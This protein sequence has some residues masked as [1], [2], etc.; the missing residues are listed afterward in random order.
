MDTNNI[1]DLEELAK[2]LPKG[3]EKD[4][5]SKVLAEAKRF[6]VMPDEAVKA[7]LK[8]AE[9]EAAD[10]EDQLK[11]LKMGE[12]ERRKELEGRR[13]KAWLTK[14]AAEKEWEE[15]MAAVAP[16]LIE[17][18]IVRRKGEAEAEKTI[19]SEKIGDLLENLKS[20]LAKNDLS[21]CGAVLKKLAVS[22]RTGEVL[23]YYGYPSNL[24]GLHK[25]FNEAIISGRQVQGEK[26]YDNLLF[27]QK[28]YAIE[29]EISCLAAGQNQWSLAFSVGR[30]GRVGQE[31][32]EQD[33]LTAVLW[34]V[35]KIKPETA[36]RHFGPAAYGY[37]V[38]REKGKVGAGSDFI[39]G[40]EGKLTLMLYWKI[41][42]KQL[43]K[44]VFNTE[45]AEAI[46]ST[47]EEFA[48]LGLP[49]SFGEALKKY[50]EETKNR[51]EAAEEVWK[52]IKNI[53]A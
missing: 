8:M 37:F 16:V 5:W 42:E 31:L 51:P 24:S 34:A 47:E 23:N 44:K 32:E 36:A 53:Y 21:G 2:G 4:L 19:T 22:G 10:A 50:L 11:L 3:K 1:K 25:F 9:K 6:E 27:Q 52:E 40:Q 46:F 35:K 14:E 15:A 17:E 48:S 33:H 41:F 49:G 45:A 7:D 13:E 43:A 39:L 20:F 29:Q 28:A 12:S 38:P 30:K 26:A 18:D